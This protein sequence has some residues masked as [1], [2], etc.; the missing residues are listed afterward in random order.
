MPFAKISSK[1]IK[2]SKEQEHFYIYTLQDKFFE[3]LSNQAKKNLYISFKFDIT[4]M[5]VNENEAYYIAN[6]IKNSDFSNQHLLKTL[7]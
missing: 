7:K 1:E 5:A 6:V 3:K 2:Q 4:V